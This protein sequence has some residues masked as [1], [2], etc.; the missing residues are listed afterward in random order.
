MTVFAVLD[1]VDAATESGEITVQDV[2]MVYKTEKGK[3]KIHQTADATAGKA[4][5]KA[6]VWVC[7]WGSSQHPSCRQW[8]W[9]REFGRSWERRAATEGSLTT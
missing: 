5:A 2:A 6:V 9:A 1:H 4:P 3:V 8:P 7:S